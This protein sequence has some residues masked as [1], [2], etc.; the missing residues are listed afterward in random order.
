MENLIDE[1]IDE[2]DVW[3]KSDLVDDITNDELL[4]E[5]Y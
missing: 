3:S 2:S 5:I 4:K 1:I